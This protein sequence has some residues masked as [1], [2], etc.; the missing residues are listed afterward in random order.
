MEALRT[1]PRYAEVGVD[2][3]AATVRRLEA[4][5]KADWSKIERVA[6]SEHSPKLRQNLALVNE[7]LGRDRATA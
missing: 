7:L 1:Y 5:G 3:V 2:R 6:R 4:E